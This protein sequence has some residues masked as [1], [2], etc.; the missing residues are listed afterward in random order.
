MEIV[1]KVVWKSPEST[2]IYVQR[3][4][5]E[6]VCGVAK[7]MESLFCLELREIGLSHLKDKGW[8]GTVLLSVCAAG[9][10]DMA[11]TKNPY[12]AIMV[13]GIV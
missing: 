11:Y 9:T 5:A 8:K 1:W 3:I 13:L 12:A 2:Y 10:E 6:R 7:E 4:Q